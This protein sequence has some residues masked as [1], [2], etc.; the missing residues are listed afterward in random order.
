MRRN[1]KRGSIRSLFFILNYLTKTKLKC[2]DFESAAKTGTTLE[3]NF[4]Q[5]AL[6][7]FLKTLCENLTTV[8]PIHIL[9]DLFA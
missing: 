5:Y 6:S 4:I 7:L 3:L 1:K 2:V 8:S 9:G